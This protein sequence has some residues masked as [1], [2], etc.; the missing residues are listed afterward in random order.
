MEVLICKTNLVCSDTTFISLPQAAS[1]LS[2]RKLGKR[3]STH[4]P[5]VLIPFISTATLQTLTQYKSMLLLCVHRFRKIAQVILDGPPGA[6]RVEGSKEIR[7][8]TTP[9]ICFLLCFW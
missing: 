4:P 8:E 6:L 3:N 5:D 2:K 9:Y 1:L 7:T